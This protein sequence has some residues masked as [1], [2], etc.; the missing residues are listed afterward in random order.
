MEIIELK[1]PRPLAKPRALPVFD[2]QISGMLPIPKPSRRKW[3]P[4]DRVLNARQ[5]R[6]DFKTALTLQQLGDLLWHSSRTRRTARVAGNTLWTSK[7]SPSGGG[8]HPVQ[9]LVLRAPVLKDKLLLYDSD[10]HVFGVR[11]VP[12]VNLIEKSLREVDR[13]LEIHN[14]TV[15]W[16]VADLARSGARYRNPESLAWRDSGALLATLGLVA[17]GMGLECCGLGLH[18][19]PAMR[20]FLKLNQSVI[21]VGGCIVG[22]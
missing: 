13:C 10:H 8:C 15:I 2:F 5:S 9:M 6:R 16:F 21:G 19:I 11:E 14:G 1:P 18:D 12:N 4:L 22:C 3:R 20:R 7:P 17:E